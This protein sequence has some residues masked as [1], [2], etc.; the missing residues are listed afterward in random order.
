MVDGLDGRWSRWS[1][2]SM[3]STVSS[4]QSCRSDRQQP[5]LARGGGSGSGRI[6]VQPMLAHIAV[7]PHNYNQQMTAAGG[8][9]E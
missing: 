1:T 8:C 2:V 3:G 9:I 7:K 4:W 5:V 6:G